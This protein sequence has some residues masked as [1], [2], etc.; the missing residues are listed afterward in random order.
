MNLCIDAV[1]LRKALADIEAA[2]KN[3][4]MH[5]LAVFRL[6]S[7]GRMIDQ[8]RMENSGKQLSSQPWFLHRTQIPLIQVDFRN[9]EE[10][11]QERLFDEKGFAVECEGMCGV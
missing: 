5:C 8:N 3:G 6:S 10:A 9:A 4:F 11:G 2:E 1:Q 7:T